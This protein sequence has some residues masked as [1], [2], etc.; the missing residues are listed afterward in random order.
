MRCVCGNPYCLE[1]VNTISSEIALS[2][3]IINICAQDI[4]NWW[5][6]MTI[7]NIGMMSKTVDTMKQ[8]LEAINQ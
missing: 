6:K 2:Q 4:V 3:S 7:R 8:A 5:P 1:E